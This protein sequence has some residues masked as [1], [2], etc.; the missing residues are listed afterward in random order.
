[1]AILLFAVAY[2][3]SA[4]ELHIPLVKIP[5]LMF[6]EEHTTELVIMGKIRLPRVIM[7]ICVGGALSLAG[8]LLQGIY[9]NPLVEPY[10]LGISGGASLGVSLSIVAAL[11]LRW[12]NSIL[13]IA[14]FAGAL[15]TIFLVYR[16]SISQK[17]LVVY[18]M[19]L[20]GVMI[21]F[22]S[23]SLMMLLMATTTTENLHGIIFWMM[24]SLDE[25]DPLLLRIVVITSLSC[26]VLSLLF[27]RPL[28]ALRLGENEARHMG[29]NTDL[30][31]K[32]LFVMASLLT[33]TS[34]A[35]AGVI[36][37]V[38][39]IIP[40]FLRLVAGSDF[41]FL[42]PGAFIFG[43]A[44]LVFCDTLARTMIA[45]NEIPIG[46]ITGILGGTGLVIV[47]LRKELQNTRL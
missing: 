36:G 44:F 35:I 28:N 18:K 47:L 24:G 29:I 30:T 38:G 23:S 33:G 31:I 5:S 42:L 45:P 11:H 16:L 10:T 25:T 40:Q 9:R 3:L 7:G 4:G 22:I 27:A 1:M 21:S 20:I 39:L 41:R 46:V 6:S 19:V 43:G 17:K 8:V 13:P 14:G 15:L 26:M 37:F 12:G 2:S 32:I 34:V